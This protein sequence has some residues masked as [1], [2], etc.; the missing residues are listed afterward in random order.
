[1]SDGV[2]WLVVAGQ[3][4][5]LF[6]RVIDGARDEGGE[7]G[8]LLEQLR[9]LAGPR[10]LLLVADSG[11]VTRSSLAAADAAGIRFVSRLPR[12]FDYES[13]A[14]AQ[15]EDSWRTLAYLAERSRRLLPA[16]RPSYRGACAT[17]DMVGPHDKPR[18][19]RVLYIYGFEYGSEEAAAARGWY[20]P[21]VTPVRLMVLEAIKF[22]WYC[23]GGE[24][25]R[26]NRYT[27][28]TE[29]TIPSLAG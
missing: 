8:Q 25:V 7:P 21:Q 16:E 12:S 4:S 3:G 17:I 11:L 19:F 2:F 9:A 6:A 27:I 18:R 22:G 28:P 20:P 10:R 24:D 5:P 23:L 29:M 15:P 1:V 26:R 13:D 14:L